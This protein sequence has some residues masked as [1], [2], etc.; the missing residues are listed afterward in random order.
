MWDVLT[1]AWAL[2]P[3]ILTAETVPCEVLVEDEAAGRTNR[4]MAGRAVTAALDCDPEAALDVI[5]RRLCEGR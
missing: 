5:V 4:Q 2:E 3:D 1:A